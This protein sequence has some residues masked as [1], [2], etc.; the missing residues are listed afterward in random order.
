MSKKTICIKGKSRIAILKFLI[1]I[2]NHYKSE[3]IGGELFIKQVAKK[4]NIPNEISS[5]T[6]MTISE[7]KNIIKRQCQGDSNRKEFFECTLI[8]MLSLIT[9]PNS[10]KESRIDEY[11]K[12]KWAY[13]ISLADGILPEYAFYYGKFDNPLVKYKIVD[14]KEFSLSVTSNYIK[15][16]TS[17]KTPVVTVVPQK[18][19]SNQTAKQITNTDKLPSNNFIKETSLKELKEELYKGQKDALRKELDVVRNEIKDEM[20]KGLDVVRREFENELRR[21][22]REIISR[23][24]QTIVQ[25]NL[26][27]FIHNDF[28]ETLYKDL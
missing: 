12:K 6:E 8:Y 20:Q 16:A 26:K 19:E 10:I 13:A 9:I 23:E 1:E 21:E 14:G 5:S 22:I 17:E 15:K 28:N 7:V 3:L 11:C 2:S 24:L 25:N 18:T 4:F 27:S